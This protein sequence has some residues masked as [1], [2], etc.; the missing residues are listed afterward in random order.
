[1]RTDA[2]SCVETG[3][4]GSERAGARPLSD[5]AGTVEKRENHPVQEA[6]QGELHGSEGVETDLVAVHAR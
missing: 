3:M 4:A 5:I 1:M 2:S 6:R